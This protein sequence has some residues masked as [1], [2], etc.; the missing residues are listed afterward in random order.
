MSSKK[1][2]FISGLDFK[3]KSIQVIRKTPEAYRDAG[4]RVDY[5]VARDN[6]PNGNYFYE[7]I[8]DP[9]GIRVYRIYWPLGNLR[10]RIGRYSALL[11]GKIASLYMIVRLGFRAWVLFRKNR[12][13]IVYGYE[14]QGVL[15]LNLI[16]F[17][18][19]RGT[20]TVSRFQGTFLNEM[21]VNRQYLRI[22][23]N[24]DHIFAIRAHSDLIIMTDDGT[25]GDSAVKK[26]KGSKSYRMAFWTNGVDPLPQH[27]KRPFEHREKTVFVSVSRLVGWKRVDRN[28]LI[29]QELL[30]LD[31]TNFI[32]YVI[33]DGDQRKAL[34]ELAENLGLND[35]VVFVGSLKNSSVKQFLVNSNIFLSMYE[36]SNVGNPLLE[37]IRA[38]KIIVTLSN[39]STG[40]WISHKNSGL[41]YNEKKLNFRKMAQ[42]IIDLIKSEA[43]QEK[44]KSRLK[45]LEK[46]KLSTWKER[47]KKEVAMVEKI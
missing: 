46:Q 11:I 37:A 21:F 44:M 45:E 18:L 2:L 19:P 25:Q 40:D 8:I 29:M 13:D 15:A 47:M 32:Y 23:F 27:V 26:I 35:H 1:I 14:L 38:N 28:L 34:E 36:S 5:L 7:R 39:G 41:I 9:K 16:K 12:Y 20:V 30:A 4:F 6:A 17:L 22:L 33:G 42:D 43:D 31:Y 24:L 10:S 3:E